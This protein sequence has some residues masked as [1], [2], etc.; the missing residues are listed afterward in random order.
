MS[1][2]I[3]FTSL[4]WTDIVDTTY[5]LTERSADAAAKFFGCVRHSTKRLSEMPELGTVTRWEDQR[6]KDIRIWP[7]KDFPNHLIFY[8]IETDELVVLRVL[9]GSTDYETLF[10]S[11]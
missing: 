1:L 6:T 7:V 8:Q 9:H 10:Q 4:A 5:Y 3:V 2:R 11:S